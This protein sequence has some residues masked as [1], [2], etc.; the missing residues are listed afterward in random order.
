MQLTLRNG[1]FRTVFLTRLSEWQSAVITVV[2][3]MSAVLPASTYATAA[4][5]SGFR[6]VLDQYQFGYGLVGLGCMRL[7]VLA[8]NGL[9]QPMY[10]V[11]AF[12]ALL[13]TMLWTSFAAAFAISGAFGALVVIVPVF[14]IFEAANVFRA[15]NDAAEAERAR[16]ITAANI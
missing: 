1:Y 14:L 11:R 6:E 10:F 12:T 13:Q 4:G 8:L 3:G 2:W 7:C 15:M 5:Y 16:R 9:W